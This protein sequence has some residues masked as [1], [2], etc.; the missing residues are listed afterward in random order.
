MKKIPLKVIAV[1]F[2]VLGALIANHVTVRSEEA[3]I[4]KVALFVGNPPSVCRPPRLELKLLPSDSRV[5]DRED[6]SKADWYTFLV[7]V[8]VIGLGY[9]A[10]HQ[11][12]KRTK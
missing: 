10:V 4:C 12:K 8:A 2:V 6:F 3:V 5:S 11:T 1:C 9:L 7:D